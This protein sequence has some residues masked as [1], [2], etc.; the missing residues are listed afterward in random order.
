MGGKLNTRLMEE[1]PG[2]TKQKWHRA[3]GKARTHTLF[4]KPGRVQRF[5]RQLPSEIFEGG[6][7]KECCLIDLSP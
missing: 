4:R 6:V 1:T 3:H 5:S 2:Q 7:R